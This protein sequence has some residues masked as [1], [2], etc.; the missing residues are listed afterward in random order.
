EYLRCRNVCCILLR[1]HPLIPIPLKPFQASGHLV[2]HGETVNVDLRRTTEELWSDTRRDFRNPINRMNRLGHRFELDPNAIHLGEFVKIYHDTMTRVRADPH[3]FFSQ[4]YFR[5]LKGA[6]GDRFMLAHTRDPSGEITSSGIFTKCSGIVQ[7]HLSGNKLG[8]EG[9][10]GSKLLL[11]GI[12]QWAKEQ[13]CEH[14]HLGGG[15]G[16]KNDSLFLFKSGFSSGRAR[17]HTWRLIVDDPV[18]Q[19]LCRRWEGINQMP[20]DAPT[21]FFP[22]YR[23]MLPAPEVLTVRQCA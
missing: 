17:F 21:G 4:E 10:D 8:G 20:V 1:F 14:F 3:Y 22:A 11:H 2:T 15:V 7:Y 6:L 12:R 5:G 16:A 9:S 18:Y 23:K 19:R 13:G